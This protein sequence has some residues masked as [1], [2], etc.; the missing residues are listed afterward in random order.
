MPNHI[1]GLFQP[2]E[3]HELEEVL[4]S[5]KG[6]VSTQLTKQGWK[7]GRL[8]QPDTYDRLVRDREELDARRRYVESNPTEA[9]L[10]TGGFTYYRCGWLDET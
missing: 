10:K 7:T 9:G 6:Y 1:H 8:W 5:V 3:G 4:A 2:M